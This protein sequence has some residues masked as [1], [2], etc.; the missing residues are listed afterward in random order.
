MLSFTQSHYCR[1]A[2]VIGLFQAS[3]GRGVFIMFS[4]TQSHYCRLANVI[5]LFQASS[6]RGVFIMLSFTQSHYCRLANVI[7]LFQASSGRGVFNSH[8]HLHTCNSIYA[9]C[10]RHTISI[11]KEIYAWETRN[12]FN[13][14]CS[15]IKIYYHFNYIKSWHKQIISH[16][17][18]TWHCYKH[19]DV[20]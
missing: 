1:L 9:D 19:K 17:G 16:H 5:G 15:H 11:C 18:F 4:F 7:G 20:T 3:S 6:G 14:S 2:N 10:T 12:S 8:S 13:V